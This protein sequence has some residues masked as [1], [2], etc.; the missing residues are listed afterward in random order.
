[1]F[2]HFDIDFCIYNKCS[3]HIYCFYSPL[4]QLTLNPKT[5]PNFLKVSG[6]GKSVTFSDPNKQAAHGGQHPHVLCNEILSS[7]QHYWEVTGY[8]GAFSSQPL[9]DRQSW[10]VGVCTKPAAAEAASAAKKGTS[11]LT[12]KHGFWIL[13]YEKGTGLSVNTDPVTPV[14]VAKEFKKLGV[15]LDCD[16]HT[17]SFYDATDKLHL[18]TFNNIPPL[19][20]LIPLICPGIKDK[21][22]MHIGVA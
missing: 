5:A 6:D 12:P 4:V 16:K 14:P 1:M 21:D 18:C 7:H 17:L 3:A 13:R 19:Q 2:M 10:Y 22:Y 15:Y 20:T 8:S 9:Y 11:L